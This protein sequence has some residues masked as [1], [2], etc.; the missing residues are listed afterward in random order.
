MT[1]LLC[2]GEKMKKVH[3][4]G[5]GHALFRC[6][7]CGLLQTVPMPD[8][9]ELDAYYQKYDVMGERDPYYREAW[10]ADALVSV[11]GRE[12]R[13]RYAWAKGVCGPLGRVLDVGSGPGIF[14]RILKEDGGEA[15]GVELNARAAERSGREL[16]VPV[17]SGTIDQV[18]ATDFDA[19]TLWDILEH[20]ADPAG[21]VVACSRR[22]KG[23]GWLLVETPDEGSLLDSAVRLLER[24]GIKGPA[25]VFYGLHHLILFRKKTIRRLLEANGFKTISI[26]GAATDPGR[27]FRGNGFKD[28]MARLSLGG[29]FLVARL[30]GRQNKMFIAA[31]KRD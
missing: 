23:G 20:V 15:A 27:I 28:K 13:K 2:V 26:R 11:E 8:A 10:G 30:V 18:T 21:F 12:A 25:K 19:V 7:A 4:H 22:L 1:C 3:D 9:V 5:D 29:L 14:L 16:G 24:L 31:K 17:V 6:V